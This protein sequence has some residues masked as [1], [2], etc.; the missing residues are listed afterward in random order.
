MSSPT[1]PILPGF[2]LQTPEGEQAYPLPICAEP[3][4]FE[5]PDSELSE[6]SEEVVEKSPSPVPKPPS[7]SPTSPTQPEKPQTESSPSNPSQFAA[8]TLVN[9]GTA[10]VE[11]PKDLRDDDESPMGVEKDT[12]ME[13]ARKDVEQTEVQ[14]ADLGENPQNP[15]SVEKDDVQQADNKEEKATD[16]LNGDENQTNT[17]SEHVEKPANEPTT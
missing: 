2:S 15:S 16:G 9:L 10:P 11:L 3:A 17:H 4:D 5:I 13:D 8:E 12:P 6:G 14:H 7:P 1:K